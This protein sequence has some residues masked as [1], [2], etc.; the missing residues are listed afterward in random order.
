MGIDSQ[1]QLVSQ[2]Q[3]DVAPTLRVLGKYTHA[4][5][6]AQ[7]HTHTHTHTHT[8]NMNTNAC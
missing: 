8:Y 5:T 7:T 2:W 1:N 3:I 4:H 6:Q